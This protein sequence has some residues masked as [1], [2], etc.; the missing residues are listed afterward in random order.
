MACS[1]DLIGK[2]LSLKEDD[3]EGKMARVTTIISY[4]ATVDQAILK[5]ADQVGVS[6]T[7]MEEIIEAG[8]KNFDSWVP[9]EVTPDD[10]CM[11]SYTSGTTGNPKGVKLTHKMLVQCS[12]SVNARLRATNDMLNHNDTY[13]SYLP[14]AHSFE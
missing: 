14:S 11:F 13:M 2:L 7:T 6:V 4:E 5:R 8:K 3:P 9:T 10:C 12:A 1:S